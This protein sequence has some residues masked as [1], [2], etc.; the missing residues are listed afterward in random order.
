MKK[1]SGSSSHYHNFIDAVRSRNSAS[2]NAEVLQGHLSSA[3]C[4]TG[5]VSYLLGQTRS[6]EEIRDK[7]KNNADLSEAFGRMEQ[8]LAANNVD[9]HKT[10]ARL[11]TLLS[12]NPKSEEFVGN[13]QANK[14]LTREYRKPFVV[15]ERV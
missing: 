5:N 10:P 1:F 6:P 15:P 14:L 3:L 7:I 4:H 13:P 9:L 11:G 12:M 8:H 2:L